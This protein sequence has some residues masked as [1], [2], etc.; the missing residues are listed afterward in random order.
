MKKNLIKKQ[1]QK[2]KEDIKKTKMEALNKAKEEKD[3]AKEELNKAKEGKKI[4]KEELKKLKEDLKKVKEEKQKLKEEK[5]KLKE[6]KQKLK[7]L[8]NPQT[9]IPIIPNLENEENIIIES[10][11]QL[12]CIMLKNGNQCSIKAHL[13]G[14]C[15]RHYNLKNKENDEK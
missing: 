9:Q 13:E 5:Q 7:F 1:N 11:T 15:K 10:S 14:L 3:K 6:E 4:L 2:I 8:Q 12:C